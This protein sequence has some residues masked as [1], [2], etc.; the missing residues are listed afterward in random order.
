MLIALLSAKGSPGVTVSA[1]ALAA[2][3]PRT[4][5]AVDF[6]P[7]GGDVLVGVGGGH[8]PA[9]RGIVELIV[10]AR[11][12]GML[13]ALGRQVARP[14]EHS[15]LVLPGF[16]APGQAA[17]VPWELLARELTD[18]PNTDVLADCGRFALDHPVAAVLHHCDLAVV[19]TGSSLRSIRATARTLPLIRR[20]LAMPTGEARAD[21]PLTLVVV[22]PDRPY[23]AHD[24]ATS[25]GTDVIGTLPS[26]VSGAAVWSD[27]ARPGRGFDRSPLARAACVLARRLAE[28]AAGCRSASVAPAAV[29]GAARR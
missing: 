12:V 14:A 28:R 10:E 7:Q 11:T 24:I 6:D 2:Q 9:R 1:L 23:A 27:G 29:N 8:E 17:S 22:A 21:A 18:I 16:G 13:A 5:I 25:C 20:E 19:V 26:D 15:P 3:W 4:A